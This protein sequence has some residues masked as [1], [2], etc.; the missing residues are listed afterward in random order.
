MT[1]LARRLAAGQ[2]VGNASFE[3]ADAQVR[4]FIADSFDVAIS[5]TGTMFFGDPQAAF[6]NIA[7]ALRPRGRLVMPV[8]QGPERNEWIG[9]LGAALAAGRDLPPPAAGAPGPFSLA[10]PP[11]VTEMLQAARFADVAFTDVRERVYYGPDVAAALDW[12]RG[13]TYTSEVLTRL[14]PPAAARTGPAG[15]LVAQFS[16]G[17]GSVPAH[18]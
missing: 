13:F 18:C 17:P 1:G 5:R 9:E 6:T 7:R 14:D 4:P 11:A 10:D 16:A 3:Q 2:G 8:W 12:A 15:R